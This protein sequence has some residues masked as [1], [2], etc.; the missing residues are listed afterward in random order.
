MNPGAC[1]R[2][3]KTRE[4]HLSLKKESLHPQSP[5]ALDFEGVQPGR[6]L[7]QSCSS[8][9]LLARLPSERYPGSREGTTTEAVS[10]QRW[11]LPKLLRRRILLP[12][13]S[14]GDALTSPGLPRLPEGKAQTSVGFSGNSEYHACTFCPLEDTRERGCC[15]FLSQKASRPSRYGCNHP[16]GW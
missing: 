7:P 4:E 2:N 3:L 5:K 14:P 8:P 15:D 6:L 1:G 11:Q 12:Q 13:G 10:P 9:L 16:P